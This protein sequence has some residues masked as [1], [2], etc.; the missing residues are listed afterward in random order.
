MSMLA[1]LALHARTAALSDS[2]KVP[3]GMAKRK[4][5]NPRPPLQEVSDAEIDAVIAQQMAEPA[6][7]AAGSGPLHD[8]FNQQM[9]SV[10]DASDL[11]EEEKQSIL[12]AMACPCCGGGPGMLTFKLKKK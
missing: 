10:L 11:D 1:G 7:P 6:P 4:S 5:G 3:T 9:R 12:V 8:L 2:R